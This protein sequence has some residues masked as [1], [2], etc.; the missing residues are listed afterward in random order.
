M[1]AEGY[2]TSSRVSSKCNSVLQATSFGVLHSA[3]GP[4]ITL[5][6]TRTDAWTIEQDN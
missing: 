3:G 4:C 5:N 2:D 1:Q 6:K